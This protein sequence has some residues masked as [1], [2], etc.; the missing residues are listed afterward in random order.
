ML[1]PLLHTLHSLQQR[2]SSDDLLKQ[3]DIFVNA[4]VEVK[5][6]IE[7]ERSSW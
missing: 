1:H 3:V 4:K 2:K 6:E 5:K 7:S